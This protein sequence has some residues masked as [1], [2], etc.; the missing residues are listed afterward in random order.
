MLPAPGESNSPDVIRIAPGLA[1][2]ASISILILLGPF[3]LLAALILAPLLFADVL[4]RR[5]AP[6]EVAAASRRE[7]GK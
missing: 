3:G 1:V 5:F 2:V 4:T 6:C 7:S